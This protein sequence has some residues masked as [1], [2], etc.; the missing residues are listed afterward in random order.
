MIK[1]I[2]IFTLIFACIILLP[3][4]IA[5]SRVI[6]ERNKVKNLVNFIYE[7]QKKCGFYPTAYI[8]D[9]FYAVNYKYSGSVFEVEPTYYRGYDDLPSEFVLEYET[10]SRNLIRIGNC[11][12]ER[13]I[14]FGGY[15]YECAI[16][17]DNIN[18]YYEI[19][20]RVDK[21]FITC[22]K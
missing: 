19:N 3:S 5:A 12:R 4:L 20:N 9:S 11:S 2:K 13:S 16:N 7:Y 1:K 10:G 17:Q 15:N 8:F 6:I 18:K 21:E 14:I 22:I